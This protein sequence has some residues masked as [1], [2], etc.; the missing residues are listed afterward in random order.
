MPSPGASRFHRFS[1]GV[2]FDMNA[3]RTGIGAAFALISYG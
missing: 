3:A 2:D 1:L